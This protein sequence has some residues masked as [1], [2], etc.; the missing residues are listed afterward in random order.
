MWLR[1]SLIL[2]VIGCASAPITN[3][4]QLLLVPESQEITLGLASYSEILNREPISTNPQW[5]EM[6]NRVGERLAAVANRPDYQWE[7]K[8]IAAP[9]QNAFCL[10]GG[11]V[12]VY[13]G[14]LPVCQSEA[15]LAVVMSH[16]VA[17][18]LARHGGERMSQ[19]YV[20]D[21]VGRALSHLNQ[22]QQIVSHEQLTSAYGIAS[23]Y[24]FVLPYSRKHE[25]EADHMG[26]M[27]MA[28]AGYDPREAPRFWQRFA[29]YN[30][31]GQAVEFLS[32]HPNDERRAADL[33]A[34]LPDAMVVYEQAPAK[35]GL[36][37]MLVMSA[38]SHPDLRAKSVA[39]G[40][41][42]PTS[43]D[44]DRY[45]STNVNGTGAVVAFD[46]KQSSVGNPVSPGS[47]VRKSSAESMLTPLGGNNPLRDRE[48]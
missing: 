18:A 6:V 39:K 20:V 5:I 11:K 45:P 17:H 28:Q 35:F 42:S 13:E 30:N 14:I 34:L 26:L 27:L 40:F 10:P 46:T 44:V 7:F 21:G 29:Q 38:P 31:A 22:T 33:L 37:A 48:R 36:G 41:A 4:H 16:E 25:S 43:S 3:R 23:E 8:V 19:S 9:Q 32:T 2:V 1:C 15:G 24:G 47:T 12:A